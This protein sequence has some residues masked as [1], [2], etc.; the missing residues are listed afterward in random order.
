MHAHAHMLGREVDLDVGRSWII[1]LTM[2]AAILVVV[3]TLLLVRGDD[4][5][6]APTSAAV[7]ATSAPDRAQPTGVAVLAAR[8]RAARQ[9]DETPLAVPR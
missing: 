2:L 9:G 3:G 7:A 8:E 1:G 4:A 6:I 5:A